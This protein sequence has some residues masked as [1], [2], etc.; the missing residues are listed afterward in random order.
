V[1]WG[2]RD[3]Y[4]GGFGFGMSG[5]GSSCGGCG[6]HDIGIG[7]GTATGGMW[8]PPDLASQL[9]PLLAACHVDDVP[10]SV[11]L[12]MTLV[13]IVDLTVQL[14]PPSD[15]SAAVRRQQQT[16]VEDALWDAAPMIR[17][18]QARATYNVELAATR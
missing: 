18:I 12:E 17:R 2:G 8:T 9:R 6:S 14:A 1:E 10:I 5:G 3:K 4:P 13:E 15:V 16:C 7:R 11:T